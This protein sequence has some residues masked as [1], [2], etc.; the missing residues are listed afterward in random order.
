M[1]ETK[2]VTKSFGSKLVLRDVSLQFEAGYIYGIVGDNGAGKSTLFNCITQLYSYEGEIMSTYPSLKNAIA[3]LQAETYF[4]PKITGEEYLRFVLNARQI[5]SDDIL[6][7]NIFELPLEEYADNYS[8]GMKKKLGLMA[9]LLMDSPVIILDEPFNGL[10]L[11]SCILVSE[12]LLALK[13]KEKIILI[14]SHIFSTLSQIC[15]QII[16]LKNDSTTAKFLRDQYEN[17][18]IE[19]RSQSTKNKLSKLGLV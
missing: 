13:K 18:E 4:F 3:Y 7:K 1:L 8:T 6:Q 5:K 19:L 11:H 14:S 10:D 9:V 12:V 16:V 2:N 17:L 15:D